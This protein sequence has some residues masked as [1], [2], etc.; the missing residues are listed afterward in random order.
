MVKFAESDFHY[1][2][3]LAYL[4]KL[5]EVASLSS[6]HDK[7]FEKRY[8]GSKFEKEQLLDPGKSTRRQLSSY[9]RHPLLTFKA[10]PTNS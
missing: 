9:C 4:N 3:I 5:C 10:T 7:R 6:A 8:G 2:D 1:R